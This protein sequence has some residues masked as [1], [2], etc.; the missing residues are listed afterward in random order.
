M[1]PH[2]TD[3][4]KR[5]IALD[6]D[7]Y[8]VHIIEIGG[9]VGDIEGQPFLEAIRQFAVENGRRNCLFLHVTLVPYI[10]LL[11]TSPPFL[12]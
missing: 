3:E 10:C 4:I 2:I 11:Y 1:I 6:A 5:R 12:L 9:T 8:D 7:K